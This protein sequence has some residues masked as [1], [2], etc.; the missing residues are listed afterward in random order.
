MKVISTTLK[1]ACCPLSFHDIAWVKN[2]ANVLKAVSEAHVYMVAKKSRLYFGNLKFTGHKIEFDLVGVHGRL[3]VSIPTKEPIFKTSAKKTLVLDAG[4][5][6]IH[7]LANNEVVP[8]AHRLKIY[9]VDSGLYEKASAKDLKKCL[10]EDSFVTWLTPE[11]ILYLYLSKQLHIPNFDKSKEFFW[12][13]E[14]MFI[15]KVTGENVKA[16]HGHHESILDMLESEIEDYEDICDDVVLLFF[17]VLERDNSLLIG[18]SVSINEFQSPLMGKNFPSVELL[19]LE[20][21]RV[22]IEKFKPKYNA[23]LFHSNF[24]C[25]GDSEFAKIDIA[26]FS[27][28]DCI[29]LMFKGMDWLGGPKGNCLVYSKNEELNVMPPAVFD[30][31]LERKFIESVLAC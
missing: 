28:D 26:D 23:A 16:H 5:K 15:G 18:N 3:S 6:E 11:K 25:K 30:D 10:D 2:D 17:D 27:V 8:V 31:F 14:V 13:Y 1:L 19:S 24:A 20:T 22:F 9:E 29:T 12:D 21:E 7:I 4:D